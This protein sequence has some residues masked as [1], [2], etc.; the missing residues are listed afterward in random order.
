MDFLFLCPFAFVSFAFVGYPLAFVVACVCDR[1]NGFHMFSFSFC[2]FS[3]WVLCPLAFVSYVIVCYLKGWWLFGFAIHL[4]DLF[5]LISGM[6]ERLSFT[7]DPVVLDETMC[8]FLVFLWCLI[9]MRLVMFCYTSPW[10]W[11]VLDRGLTKDL[12]LLQTHLC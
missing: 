12:H 1:D 6:I 5:V 7:A 4:M 10:F 8:N 3:S 11:M 9:R 2:W